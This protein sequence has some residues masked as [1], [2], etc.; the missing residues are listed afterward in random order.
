MAYPKP[1]SIY[2]P[3]TITLYRKP[4]AFFEA[5]ATKLEET[6]THLARLP[7]ST[8]PCRKM[9][10][11]AFGSIVPASTWCTVF[12][13]IPYALDPKSLQFQHLMMPFRM[14]K[15]KTGRFFWVKGRVVV[16]HSS[17]QAATP[18]RHGSITCKHAQGQNKSCMALST[19]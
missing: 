2:L 9:L 7:Q 13:C 19:T 15:P 10:P 17:F 6:L 18:L 12:G 1:H 8:W 5:L 11:V 16:F 14:Q 3:G 4:E